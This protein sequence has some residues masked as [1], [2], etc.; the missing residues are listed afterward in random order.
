MAIKQRGLPLDVNDKVMLDININDGSGVPVDADVMPRISIVQPGGLVYLA[1]TITGVTK[2]GVGHY[3]YVF[4]VPFN[5]PYGVWNDI[6]TVIINGYTNVQ[7]LPCIITGTQIPENP[8]SDGFVHLGDAF[9]LNYS[10]TA[11]GNINKLLRML[12]ARLNSDGKSKAV[13]SFG[14][15]V[16]I[17]C[18]NFS[19]DTLISFLGLAITYFNQIPYFTTFTYD[20]SDFVGQ[21][22][23]ILV[24]IA[25]AHAMAS[26][27]LIEKGSEF[28]LNDNG[29]SFNPG[30]VADMLNTQAA[31]LMTQSLDMLKTIKNSMR[32]SPLGLGSFSIT[33]SGKSPIV[34]ALSHLRQGRVV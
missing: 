9:P 2:L 6:W 32:P 10:Q 14:N 22:G 11:T 1:P 23:A 27:A 3:G 33:S 26:K 7:N 30:T 31:A 21:F 25:A 16:Y 34:K 8:S 28:T 12:K 18:S 15:T 4:T 17:T 13:D 24:D 19:N 20:D 5:G 29:I